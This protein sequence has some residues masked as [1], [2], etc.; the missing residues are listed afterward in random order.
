[1][2][3]ASTP[4]LVGDSTPEPE[5]VLDSGEDRLEDGAVPTIDALDETKLPMSLDADAVPSVERLTELVISLLV[6]SDVA[7][8]DE[9]NPVSEVE[10]SMLLPLDSG[11]VPVEE[12]RVDIVAIES[13]V[14]VLKVSFQPPVRLVEVL[15]LGKTSE[16]DGVVDSNV[17][18]VT[19]ASELLRPCELAD[20]DAA[21]PAVDVSLSEVPKSVSCSLERLDEVSVLPLVVVAT[22]DVEVR[23]SGSEGAEELK[24]PEETVGTSLVAG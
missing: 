4:S 10:S 5:A 22:P 16:S 9:L 23:L 12:R 17:D 15:R 8:P 14:E 19:E 21:L 1:M 18:D 11:L 20:V 6:D 3:L 2:E 24:F 7:P 13:E